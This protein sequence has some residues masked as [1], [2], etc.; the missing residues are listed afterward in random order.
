MTS[1]NKAT[2]AHGL[3][4]TRLSDNGTVS[5]GSY[6]GGGRVA[7]ELA[8]ARPWPAGSWAYQKKRRRPARQ[9]KDCLSASSTATVRQS[10]IDST[11]V[12]GLSTRA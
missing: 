12:P 3:P 8:L 1:F 11:C 5:T 4:A 10:H 2:A 6:R 7:L 9:P